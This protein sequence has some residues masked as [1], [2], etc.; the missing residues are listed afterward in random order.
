MGKQKIMLPTRWSLAILACACR[1]FELY[2]VQTTLTLCQSKEM[3]RMCDVSMKHHMV[4]PLSVSMNMRDFQ[5]AIGLFIW[6]LEID[7]LTDIS[8]D[9]GLGW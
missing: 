3:S 7:K 2:Q 8:L 4:N 9:V 1:V 6:L 5:L